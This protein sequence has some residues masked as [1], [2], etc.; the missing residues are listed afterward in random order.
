MDITDLNFYKYH[1]DETNHSHFWESSYYIGEKDLE[2]I[3]QELQRTFHTAKINIFSP[4]SNPE[5]DHG[6]CVLE[7]KLYSDEDNALFCLFI[8]K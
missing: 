4:Y 6:V 2:K 7:V 5:I 3:R 1:E 8:G